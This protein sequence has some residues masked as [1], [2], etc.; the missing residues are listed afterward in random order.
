MNGNSY[1]INGHHRVQAALRLG[2]NA[3]V[4]Y[5]NTSGTYSNIFDLQIAA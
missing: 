2:Q 3:P 1:I 4:N 5:L